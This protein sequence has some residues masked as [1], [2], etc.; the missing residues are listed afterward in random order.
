M[1]NRRY[2]HGVDMFM[3]ANPLTILLIGGAGFIGS[4]IAEKFLVWA[5]KY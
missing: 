1:T 3:N 5:I 4:N 2:F